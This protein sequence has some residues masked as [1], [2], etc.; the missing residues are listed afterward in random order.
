MRASRP[1]PPAGAGHCPRRRRSAG[2]G[3]AIPSGSGSPRRPGPRMR[4]PV[5]GSYTLAAMEAPPPGPRPPRWSWWPSRRA[6][7]L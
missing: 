2:V 6:R 1:P 5:E 3:E 4:R 7:P